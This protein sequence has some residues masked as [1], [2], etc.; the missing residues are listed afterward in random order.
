M[1]KIVRPWVTA[2]VAAIG[3]GIVVV[4]PPSA[5]KHQVQTENS[6]VVQEETH[7]PLQY[8]PEVLSRS[9]TNGRRLVDEYL[10]DPLPVVRA[11]ADNQHRAVT[12]ILRS[13]AELD[14][15]AFA[16]AVGAA[17]SQPVAS[18]G[19]V[20]ASGEPVRTANSLLVRL[21]LPAASGVLAGGAGAAE[22]A[23]AVTDLDPV[24]VADG[25]VN[26][27]ARTVDGLLNGH[28]DGQP[29]EYFG[30][31]GSVV[32][33]PVSEDISGPVDYL[34]GSLRDI[35]DMIAAPPSHAAAP[36]DPPLALDVAASAPDVPADGGD[37][38]A[39][40]PPA[41]RTEHRDADA[42]ADDDARDSSSEDDPSES[43]AG[44][45]RDD[46]APRHAARHT[47]ATR[48]P[49]DTDGP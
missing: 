41:G 4:A 40:T 27:P 11:I 45:G 38:P 36:A 20:V 25:L 48:T 14:P 34:I 12:D 1:P 24:R 43:R 3:V 30:L 46:A 2:G 15:K 32:E 18:L 13:A 19:R 17:A 33:A 9:L 6:A 8:Y 21:T 42:A 5:P 29:D 16:H 44:Q 10:E 39:L 23:D 35:G 22:V 31:L 26:L 37:A 28:V 47:R 7:S 49:S